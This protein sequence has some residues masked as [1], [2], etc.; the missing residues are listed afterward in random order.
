M[1]GLASQPGA[2]TTSERLANLLGENPGRGFCES[3][4]ARQLSLEPR[5]KVHSL[6]STLTLSDLYR[7]ELRHCHGCGRE[8]LV[9]SAT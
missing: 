2:P 3:C 7:R 5:Q 9:I 4:I 6:T 1:L 8:K